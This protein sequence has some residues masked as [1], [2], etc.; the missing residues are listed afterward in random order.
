MGAIYKRE[1]IWYVDLRVN[2]Q[3][4]RKKAGKS[5]HLAELYLKDLE[6]KSERNQLGFLERREI[7]LGD[8]VQ[9]FLKYSAANHRPPTTSRYRAALANFQRFIQQETK[10]K[11]LSDIT[12][13]IVEKYK[14]WRRTTP[15]ARNGADPKRVIPSAVS[16][17]AKSYTVNFEIMTVKTILNL[18]V[19]WKYLESSPAHGVKKL[20]N[21]D[22][23]PRRFLSEAEC[24][25]L[26]AESSKEYYPIF[27]TFLNTGMR[28]AEL[29]NLEW[30]D[31]NFEDR[32]IRI[33]RKP[34]WMPKT[35]EREIPINDELVLVLKRLPKRGNFVFTDKA[36]KQLNADT[37]RKELVVIAKKAGVPSLTEIHALRHT[38]A[39]QLNKQGVDLPSIQK[40]MGHN[41]IE[42]TMI[43]THQT[44]QHLREAISRLKLAPN[45]AKDAI[46]RIGG[47]T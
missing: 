11:R 42:T 14:T 45:R 4:V 15:V 25:R 34:F 8:F 22:T 10:V 3:R 38:F 41:S 26:L 35:G 20:K 46:V 37:V 6:L 47:D 17:G 5:K 2:G 40:L 7:A 33:R 9:E 36:G 28:R 39:S 31:V 32:I 24:K 29:V 12:T 43:Y 18:A 30:T 13:E 27:F 21:E 1:G 16:K 19:K 44:T 23:K